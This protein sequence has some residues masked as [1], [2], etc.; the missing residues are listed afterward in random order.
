MKRSPCARAVAAAV[1]VLWICPLVCAAPALGPSGLQ[2]EVV[3]SNYSQLASGPELLRR[4]LSPLDALQVQQALAQSGRQLQTQSLNLA[5]ERF[6]LYV[7]AQAPLFG[8]ALLV[9]VPPWDDARLPQGWSAVLDRYGM[10]FVSAARSGNDQNVT[11]RREPLALLAAYNVM[12]RYPVAAARVFVAGF[13]GGSRV[14]MRLALAYPDLFRGA[15]LNAGS[16]PL[17]ARGA[18]QPPAELFSQLQSSS[19]LIYLTGDRDLALAGDAESIASMHK[20][21]VFN[22][23]SHVALGRSHEAASAAALDG[24]LQTLLAADPPDEAKLASCRTGI[25]AEVNSQL[26]KVQALLA[27]GNRSAA[28]RLLTETDRYFG[29]LAA[30]R[31]VELQ[32]AL[33]TP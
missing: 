15:L 11:A 14:A 24:A 23:G 25:T 31:S 28:Q 19:R 21:C 22:I 17:G 6:I 8:Y 30:P 18:I 4:T 20:W 2:R 29:G 1:L 3:F 27:A 33:S 7:P 5:E 26:D 16:D 32:N 9:F 13:S 10:I 12:Q